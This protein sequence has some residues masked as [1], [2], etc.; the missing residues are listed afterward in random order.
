MADHVRT[1]IRDAAVTLATGLATTGARVYKG[2]IKALSSGSNLPC[3]VVRVE[4]EQHPADA[5]TM[6]GEISRVTELVFEGY[7]REATGDEGHDTL[8]QML[9]E[10]EIQFD[11]D[12]KLG[13]ILKDSR[14]STVE[15]DDGEDDA[16]QIIVAMRIVYEV[17]YWTTRGAPDVAI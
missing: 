12:R 13:G 5:R 15:F 14:L 10:L 4:D 2:R 1:Q 3:F 8:D 7:A 17:E 16:S 9:K 6:D 11:T